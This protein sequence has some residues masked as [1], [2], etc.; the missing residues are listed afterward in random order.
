MKSTKKFADLLDVDPEI[1]QQ[2]FACVSFI[3]PEKILKD[4]NEFLF[5]EFLKKWDFINSINKF[6][7]FINFVSYKYS[8]NNDNLNNDFKD[9]VNEEKEKLNS[10]SVSDEFKTFLDHNEDK[11]EREFNLQNDFQTSTRGLKIR[12]CYPTLEEAELRCKMIRDID[13]NHDVYVGPIGTW[14]PWEPESYKTGRVEHLEP[15]LNRLMHEKVKNDE[16]A[17]L[18]FNNRVKQAK[19][20]AIEDNVKKAVDSNNTLTQRLDKEGNLVNIKDLDDDNINNDLMTNIKEQLF[21]TDDVVTDLNNDH[22]L[23][24]LLEK[25]HAKEKVNSTL[26]TDTNEETQETNTDTGEK[27]KKKNKKKSKK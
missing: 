21:N 2:K 26:K 16:S 4:K 6:S 17:K 1:A 18:N 13:S 23:G 22:G 12:G 11:L 20:K 27:K 19:Q 10:I 8:I 5:Q 14:M 9:F 15:E 3:S 7:Q 24:E 25:Q